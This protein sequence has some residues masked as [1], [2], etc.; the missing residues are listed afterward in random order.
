M[1]STLNHIIFI[2]DELQ[3]LI[4]NLALQCVLNSD[5]CVC[6]G[7]GGGGEWGID[8]NKPSES[9]GHTTAVKGVSNTAFGLLKCSMA[10]P[11]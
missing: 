11:C 8:E 6:V 9:N 1:S 2:E 3:V 10:M 5:V 4:S 7:G